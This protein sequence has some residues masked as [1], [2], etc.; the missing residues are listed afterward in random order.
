MAIVWIQEERIRHLNNEDIEVGGLQDLEEA[1]KE[2]EINPSSAEARRTRSG[3][4]Q[5]RLHVLPAPVE[6]ATKHDNTGSYLE[7]FSLA[8]RFGARN[9]V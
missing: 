1:L 2:R 6:T 7:E 5:R 3:A 4:R 9:A 8:C